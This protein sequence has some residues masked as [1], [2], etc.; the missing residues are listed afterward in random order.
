MKRAIQPVLFWGPR[1]LCVLFAL[2]VSSFALD[3]FGEGNG[4]W[5]TTLALLAHLIP[6]AII[7]LV[8]GIAWRWEWVGAL[9]FP[10]IGI[11]YLLTAWGRFHWSVYLVIAGPLFLVGLLFL[12]DGL[13]RARIHG[14]S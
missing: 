9:F 7:L 8:L 3:V 10:G 14:E 11:W 4:F 12:A 2:F 5:K 6:T 1:V 13:Y